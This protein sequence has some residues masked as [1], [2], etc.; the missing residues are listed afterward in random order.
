MIDGQLFD[1]LELIARAMRL[2]AGLPWGGIQLIV[3]G[4]FFQLPPINVPNLLK[5]FAFE[6]ECWANSFHLQIELTHIFRQSDSALIDI[7]QGI[8]QGRKD[9]NL[10][11]VL[12]QYCSNS[13]SND[14]DTTT[15]LFPRNEDVRKLNAERMK[16]LGREIVTY[17]AIDEGK[18][19]WMGQLKLGIA[20]EELELC[21]GALVMLIKNTVAS[22]GLVNGSTGT[23]TG[24]V[25]D[26]SRKIQKMC[27]HGVLPRVRFDGG[28]ELVVDPQKWGVTEGEMVR[29]KRKQIPLILAWALSVHKCQDMTLNRLHTDLS[30][31][32]GCG[33]VYV[34]LS[35]VRSLAGLRL[36][37]FN[38]K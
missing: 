23:V 35:R 19:P 26:D 5:E 2:W 6:A 12:E 34:A 22:I 37:G 21:E 7:L 3:S 31:A 36:S 20:P 13:S 25:D 16:S 1:R 15:S 17:R 11:Y 29:A 8:R 28:P 10:R 30:R 4:D 14:D 24:F 18:E 9:E 32:F 27:G 38:T 33:M